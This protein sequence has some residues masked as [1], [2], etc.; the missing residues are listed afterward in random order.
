MEDKGLTD[1]ADNI[2][3]YCKDCDYSETEKYE[4]SRAYGDSFSDWFK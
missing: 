2:L 4:S 1:E 3:Y